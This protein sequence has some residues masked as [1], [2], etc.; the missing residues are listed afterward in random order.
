MHLKHISLFL[1]Y[2]NFLNSLQAYFS[3]HFRCLYQ[4]KKSKTK[5]LTQL[6]I[7]YIMCLLS[8][9]L[10]YSISR[11][12]SSFLLIWKAHIEPSNLFKTVCSS[13]VS[14]DLSHCSY[15]FSH[16][17]H[18]FSDHH[19]IFHVDLSWAT[20]SFRFN[21]NFMVDTFIPVHIFLLLQHE[22]S[23]TPHHL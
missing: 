22:Q 23:S 4:I 6:P 14:D 13:S 15:H 20:H 10:L 9:F 17:G 18:L 12:F 2:H 19:W 11:T 1:G 7:T 3:N 16:S 8:T 5:H 21:R